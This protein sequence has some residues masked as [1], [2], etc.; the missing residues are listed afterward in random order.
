LKNLELLNLQY[1]FCFY[2]IVKS[3]SVYVGS[4]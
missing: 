2:D 1:L 4:G 3:I